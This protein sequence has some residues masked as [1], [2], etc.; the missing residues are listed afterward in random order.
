[1]KKPFFHYLICL[2]VLMLFPFAGAEAQTYTSPDGTYT[3]TYTVS[4][5]NATITKGT[6]N[7]GFTGALDI[8]ATVTNGTT[9]YN[10]TAIGSSAFLD[11]TVITSLT[12]P[13][14]LETIGPR[15]FR[16][17]KTDGTT[18]KIA[19]KI[20]IPSTVKTL[21]F[22]SFEGNK[23][24]NEVVFAATSQ[25]TK[26]GDNVFL[27]TAITSI[28]L[29]N[30]LKDIP[31]EA[32]IDLPN[33]TNVT[34][35]NAYVTIGDRAFYNCGISGDIV[36]PST[37]TTL[38]VNCF[39]QTKNLK[40]ATFPDN[41][42]VT[43]IPNG[44]FSYS[45]LQDVSLPKNLKTIGDN[46]YSNCPNMGGFDLVLPASLESIGKEAFAFWRDVNTE[47]EFKD[48]NKL[49]FP[50]PSA[51]TTLGASAFRN[52]KWYGDIDLSGTKIT[53][54]ETQ[55]F[56]R[57]E[58]W[59]G[60]I[61]LPE[62]LTFIGANAFEL[63]GSTQDLQIPAK[64][65]ELGNEAFYNSPFSGI[66][67][68]KGTE[69]RTI[70]TSVFKYCF[71]LSYLDLSNVTNLQA[72]NASREPSATNTS[73]YAYMP[74]YTMVYLPPGSTVKP[75]E[76]NFVVA[77]KCSK[78]V[79]YD[80]DTNGRYFSIKDRTY[81]GDRKWIGQEKRITPDA[82][83]PE[84]FNMNRGC[85]YDIQYP[86]KAA[87]ATYTSRTF[88]KIRDKT[89]T[90]CLPY[91]ATVPDGLRAYKL[92]KKIDIGFYFLSVDNGKLAANQP[93][94]LRVV[95]PGGS[96][97]FGIETGE[98]GTGV[99]IPATKD[100]NLQ[101][102]EM[103]QDGLAFRGTTTNILNKEARNHNYYNLN[104]G[105]WYPIKTATETWT[106]P[107][108]DSAVNQASGFMGFVHSMRG[109]VVT[110]EGSG[111]KFATM[112]EDSKD[113]NP[114]A[115]NEMEEQIQG[116]QARIYS[117]DGRYVGTDINTLPSGNI[118]VVNGKKIYKF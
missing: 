106:G 55:T 57:N 97:T 65:I 118:Y 87:T 104:G 83:T 70:G 78:F 25:L 1:M 98:D 75:G 93:Y 17:S 24:I 30:S 99:D 10:V 16:S 9:T 40:T 11:N 52:G 79:V 77:G 95:N 28:A 94:V 72:T 53:R 66:S 36:F 33:L 116:K 39:Y 91:P 109:Y 26:L 54:I 88:E 35:P 29:P 84:N 81:S 80:G 61:T 68:Q 23:G 3:L 2:A 48:R 60:H 5:G 59:D 67:F 27:G 19:G 112:F 101:Q 58:Q 114:T 115:I 108:S 69:V 22:R 34:L 49:I 74:P 111:A 44:A 117:I 4:G 32:F 15:A 20:T 51:L 63:V 6:F 76:E 37:L 96:F 14:G 46:A 107:D 90:I 71:N 56:L 21:D 42:L 73:Q 18:G 41:T 31:L 100:A 43:A 47:P 105:I 113:I 50:N 62:N 102:T 110:P 13:E 89:Y 86:F 82:P 64:V 92:N 7:T 103:P 85:D 8:P 45:G 12:L 38:G